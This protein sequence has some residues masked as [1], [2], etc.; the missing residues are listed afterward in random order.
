MSELKRSELISEPPSLR[1]FYDDMKEHG[2]ATYEMKDK[3]YVIEMETSVKRDEYGNTQARITIWKPQEH[4][5]KYVPSRYDD[6]DL[7]QPLKGLASLPRR[8]RC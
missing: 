6:S 5:G 1:D 3:K 8:T 4:N 2:G 7:L